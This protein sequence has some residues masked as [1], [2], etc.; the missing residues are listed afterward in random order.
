M[1]GVDTAPPTVAA[2]GQ[3]QA[4]PCNKT[5]FK[6]LSSFAKR[7]AEHINVLEARAH[8]HLIR[9]LLRW[10]GRHG[11][12]VITVIDSKV[13]L[14]AFTKGRSSAASLRRACRQNA[15]LL[16]SGDLQVSAIYIN[17]RDNPA[18]EA[19]RNVRSHIFRCND[20]RKQPPTPSRVYKML[21]RV[22]KERDH[23]RAAVAAT[24]MRRLF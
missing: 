8:L 22:C 1:I 21:K 6:V 20:R 2:Y 17:T 19:S 3:P 18:D 10:P 12:P 4:V 23:G 14:G 9:W 13:V 24:A 15:A 11:R 7:D 16:L 5:D